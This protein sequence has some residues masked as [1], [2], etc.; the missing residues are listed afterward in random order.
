MLGEYQEELAAA[1]RGR[2]L[3]PANEHFRFLELRALASLGRVVEV[4]SVARAAFA[5]AP[6][7]I[8]ILG[9]AIAG[10][11]LAHGR[12]ESSRRLARYA[13]ELLAARPPPRQ[14]SAEWLQ[15]HR[16]LTDLAGEREGYFSL[17]RERAPT[18]ATS[19]WEQAKDEWLHQRAEL[20]LLLGDPEAA[21]NLAAQ[22]RDPDAHRLLPARVAGA[23][24][25]PQDARAALERGE[26]RYLQHWGTLRGLALDRAG[27]HVAMSDREG[28]LAI[29]AEGLS[30][31]LIPGSRWGNDGH[32]RPDLAPLWSD[33]RFRAL[34]KPR[35]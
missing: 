14:A 3:Y 2:R 30:R 20:A 16:H 17:P 15:E 24:G 35:G 22:L 29:L 21:G 12:A 7:Q 25:W 34:I 19:T 10:E 28:A 6:G 31:G 4:D 32:A 23:R 18:H 27:A 9:R 26:R 8:G 5:A 1:R 13:A 11:L 33:P